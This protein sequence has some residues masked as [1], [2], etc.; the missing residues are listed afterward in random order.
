MK[1]RL[2]RIIIFLLTLLIILS[3]L[4]NIFAQDNNEVKPDSTLFYSSILETPKRAVPAFD[5][6]LHEDSLGENSCAKC[7]HVLD[8]KENKL[9][10]SEGEEAAC[11][12]CHTALKEASHETCTGCHRRMKKDKKI[13][14]PTTCGECH[15]K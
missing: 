9:I 13:A 1:H 4:P 15:K 12:E 3:L 6:T 7:H 11:A 5:H 10:Y 8:T 14:G 2:P